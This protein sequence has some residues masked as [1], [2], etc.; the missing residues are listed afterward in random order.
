VTVVKGWTE[1]M[2][3]VSDLR[4]SPAT[5]ILEDIE[6]I[7]IDQ[8]IDFT[9]GSQDKQRGIHDYYWTKV[10]VLD[11][12]LELRVEFIKRIT[13]IFLGPISDDNQDEIERLLY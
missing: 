4:W 6:R 1:V 9:K 13:R 11:G 3:F 8:G 12:G 2:N 10:F 5:Q 7:L